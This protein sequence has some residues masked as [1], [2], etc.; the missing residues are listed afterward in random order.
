LSPIFI[1]KNNNRIE[2]VEDWFR[3]A[4]PKEGLRHWKDGRSAKELAKIWFSKPGTP[5]IPADL[6]SL[7]HSHPDLVS[8]EILEGTPEHKIP[9]DNF[10]G[11]TRNADLVLIGKR[12]NSKISINIEAKADEPYDQSVAN[13]LSNVKNPRSKIPNR[14]DLLCRALFGETP[15][16]NPELLNLRYQLLT[17]CAGTMIEAQ[18]IEA[19]TA[20]FVVH[21]FLS[22]AV[23]DEKVRSNDGDY[24]LFMKHLGGLDAANVDDGTLIGPLT[25]PGGPFVPSDTPLYVGKIK[26]QVT[27]P[28]C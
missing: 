5:H 16:S 9:L 6:I 17:G 21:V 25:V 7:L 12:G 15:E 14:I 28:P 26:T 24:S 2:S 22:D 23:D 18:R 4:S 1:H 13:K 8:T 10:R 19:K 3:L 20:V 27:G 11:E